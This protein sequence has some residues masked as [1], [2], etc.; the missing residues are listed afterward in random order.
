M[1]AGPIANDDGVCGRHRHWAHADG[2]NV[3]WSG[4]D[5]DR[6]VL[7]HGRNHDVLHDLTELAGQVGIELAHL[8][9]WH[10]AGLAHVADDHLL[11]AALMVQLRSRL[12]HQHL[13]LPNARCSFLS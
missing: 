13:P 5:T 7:R 6:M 10:A 9:R 2:M 11:V 4:A 1:V 8:H 3:R 12:L